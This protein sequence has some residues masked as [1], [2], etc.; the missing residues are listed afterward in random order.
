MQARFRT[1]ATL[2]ATPSPQ[3][4]TDAPTRAE[5]SALHDDELATINVDIPTAVVQILST[6]P[7][8]RQVEAHMQLRWREPPVGLVSRLERY[9]RA[10]LQA[11][12]VCRGLKIVHPDLSGMARELRE[13]RQHLL[14][15]THALVLTGVLAR[16]LLEPFQHAKGHRPLAHSVCGIVAT[17]WAHWQVIENKTPLSMAELDQAQALAQRLLRGL[18]RREAPSAMTQALR[19]RRQAFTLL[20]RE[21]TELRR[22]ALFLYPTREAAQRVPSLFGKRPR[23][24]SHPRPLPGAISA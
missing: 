12:G 11:H 3:A 10:L 9:A 4:P 8:L 23:T 2:T 20:M 21:Y 13:V 24:V 6:L 1:I 15:C 19:E 17:C 14:C 16:E 7:A 22:A 5:M 18:Q